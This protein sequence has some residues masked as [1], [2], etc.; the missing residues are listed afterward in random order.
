EASVKAHSLVKFDPTMAPNC[1]ESR[2]VGAL[3]REDQRGLLQS[4]LNNAFGQGG[5]SLLHSQDPTEVYV[6][7]Y[8]DGLPMSVVTDL[9]G[10]C[11]KEFLEFRKDWYSQVKGASNGNVAHSDIDY[12]RGSIPVYSG[13]DAEELVC[14]T[15]IVRQLYTVRDKR[16]V[17]GYDPADFPELR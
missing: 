12:S 3:Y 5:C 9:T 1:I 7:Y 8:L 13:R 4:A 14:K 11:M 10:R 2:H 6:V 16:I 17:D 15:G